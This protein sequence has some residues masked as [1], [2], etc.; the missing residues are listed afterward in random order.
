[1]MTVDVVMVITNQNLFFKH[2]TVN[3]RYFIN[4]AIASCNTQERYI[5]SETM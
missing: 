3:V 1:M 4:L 5:I 2:F